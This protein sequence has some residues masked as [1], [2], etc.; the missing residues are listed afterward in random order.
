MKKILAIGIV[1]IL[2]CGVGLVAAQKSLVANNEISTAKL[3]KSLNNSNMSKS[4]IFNMS[5]IEERTKGLS[6]EEMKMKHEEAVKEA[7][8]QYKDAMIE[9]EKRKEATQNINDLEKNY[10]TMRSYYHADYTADGGDSAEGGSGVGYSDAW[11]SGNEIHIMSRAEGPWGEYWAHGRNWD[12]FTY[13]SSDHWCKVKIYYHLRGRL[14]SLGGNND[15]QIHLRVYDRTTGTEIDNKLILSD[16]GNKY[17]DASKTGET[18]VYLM[19]GHTY[20]IE[21]IGDNEASAWAISGALADF[22]Y[23]EFDGDWRWVKWNHD[24]VTWA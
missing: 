9:I 16:H 6:E 23:Q 14:M 2:V 1:A 24:E 10:A 22:G 17:Y 7:Q 13:T 21:L 19:N 20:D 4:D 15:L 5:E 12:R 18:Q 11:T 3:N 8:E